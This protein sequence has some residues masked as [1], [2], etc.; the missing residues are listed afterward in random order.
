MVEGGQGESL[1]PFLCTAI[2]EEAIG[3]SGREAVRLAR[4]GKSRISNPFIHVLVRLSDPQSLRARQ[5]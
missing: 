5:E 2:D 4:Q 3:W 1:A